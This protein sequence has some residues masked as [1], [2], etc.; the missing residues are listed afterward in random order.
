MKKLLTA[1]IATSIMSV[2]A[3]YAE[4]AAT[5]LGYVCKPADIP[6][7]TDKRYFGVTGSDVL[8]SRLADTQTMQIDREKKTVKVWI[9]WLASEQERQDMILDMGR[10]LD[11]SNF[12]YRNELHI[13]DYANMRTLTKSIADYNC[14][15]SVLHNKDYNGIDWKEIIPESVMERITR[16][17]IKKYDLK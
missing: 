12:G 5:P 1:L 3:V 14:N 9:T 15:G 2:T 11:Y 4:D 16:S 13:I 6:W 7:I 8:P 10:F 17:I